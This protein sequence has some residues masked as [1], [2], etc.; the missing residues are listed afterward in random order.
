MLDI[1]LC[2]DNI[3]ELRQLTHLIQKYCQDRPDLPARVRRFQSLFDLIDAITLGEVFHICLLDHR[4]GQ[5][6]M[7]GLSAEALLRREASGLSIIGFTGDPHSAFLSPSPGDHLGLEA[8]LA[9]P[10]SSVDL[11]GVLDRLIS[12]KLPSPDHPA[13]LLPTPQG[14]RSL[15]FRQLIRAH[16]RDHVVSCHLTDGEV[17][18]SSVLR[19]PF[20]QLIQPLLQTGDFS[21]VSASCVVSL[22]FVEALDKEASAARLSDG[23][24]LPVPRAAFP[25]LRDNLRSYQ[26]RRGGR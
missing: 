16:Y 20:N 13:L 14:Q 2:N 19:V 8:R 6:W 12:G 26:E 11:Y 3:P 15:P 17:V 9:K 10:V 24:L 18:K 21:W 23:Q 1:V 5:P 25:G 7:N 4:G 22:A